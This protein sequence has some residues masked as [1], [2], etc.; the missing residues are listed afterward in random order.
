M[1]VEPKP[2][3]PSNRHLTFG[4]GPAKKLTGCSRLL[5]F[6]QITSTRA[7]AY[8][9]EHGQNV[10][11]LMKRGKVKTETCLNDV[12]TRSNDIQTRSNDFQT[13]LNA[14]YFVPYSPFSVLARPKRQG[15]A[16][17]RFVRR[18]VVFPQRPVV[19]SAPCHFP[20]ALW[21]LRAFIS[22]ILS[23]KLQKASN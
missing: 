14:F 10:T 22:V 17:C 9:Q 2:P 6:W 8:D 18:P 23:L 19:F 12:Q 4:Q 20:R 5:S 13:H 21:F 7:A 11:F 3:L 15:A 16:P 1:I